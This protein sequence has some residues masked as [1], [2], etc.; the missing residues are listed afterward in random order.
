VKGLVIA[1]LLAALMSSLS[2]VFN[3]CSTL[4]TIDLYQ[5][6]RPAASERQLVVVGQVATGVLVIFGLAWIPMMENFS[7]GLFVYLQKVQAYISPPIA[8]VFLLGVLWPRLNASGAAISLAVGFVLGM[9]RMV[10]EIYPHRASGLMGDMVQ[11]NFLHFAAFLFV[12]CSAVL[13]AVSLATPPPPAGGVM[14]PVTTTPDAASTAW[15]RV[16]GWAT[17]I[18][19]GL[20]GLIWAIFSG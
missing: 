11:L 5:R 6:L 18:L 7:G 12:V 19:L 17:L 1:G 10:F 8:A 14:A 20:V 9:L 3:S 15:R 13:I 16:D 4:V 2:S